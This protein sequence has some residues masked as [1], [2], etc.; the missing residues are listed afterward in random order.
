MDRL[1]SMRVFQ[2]VVDEGGFAAASRA[3]DISA[4]VVTRL[5]ADLEAHLG[6]R[7]LQRSTRR[8]SL[9]DA[10]QHYLD[11]VRSILQAIDE[12]EAMAGAQTAELEGLIRLHAPPV[13][14]S[15]VIAPLLA[16]FRRRHPRI[17]IDL[18]VAALREPPIED[19]DI[20]VMGADASFDGNVV[21]RKIL[22]SEAILVASPQYLQ[23]RG[24]PK[25]PQDLLTHD[26]LSLKLPQLQSR[27]WQLWREEEPQSV[28][29]LDVKPKISSNSSDSLVRAAIDGAGVTAVAVGLAVPHLAQGDLVRVL[30]PWITGRLAMYAAIPS[31]KFIPRRTLAFLDFLADEA[32][33]RT[34]RALFAT[35][36]G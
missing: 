1:L 34:A 35:L 16:E 6:A 14:A 7:L 23:E 25:R 31:R 17:L 3:L 28:V 11:R 8:L 24:T 4:P 9:T 2:K 32:R 19:F 20:T 36:P 27:S 15:Q 33:S 29:E 22:E 26:C 12:A 30:A 13:L 5:V 10:G 18:E 21:A